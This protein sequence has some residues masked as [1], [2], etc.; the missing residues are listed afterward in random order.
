LEED[1]YT[2]M[3]TPEDYS[4]CLKPWDEVRH[5]AEEGERIEEHHLVDESFTTKLEEDRARLAR[6]DN[7]AIA[8]DVEVDLCLCHCQGG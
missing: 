4:A 3:T 6:G 1:E 2:L 5:E 8:N 7:G